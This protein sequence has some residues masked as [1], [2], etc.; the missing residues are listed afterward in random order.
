[1]RGWRDIDGAGREKSHVQEVSLARHL[2][3]RVDLGLVLDQQPRNPLVAVLGR[4]HEPRKP[5]LPGLR[6]WT[7]TGV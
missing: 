1:M 5:V 7:G 2:I 3:R 6:A 4:R